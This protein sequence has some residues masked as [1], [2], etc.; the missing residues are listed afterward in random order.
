[1]VA[2]EE[3]ASGDAVSV[4]TGCLTLPEMVVDANIYATL[5]ARGT[6]GVLIDITIICVKTIAQVALLIKETSTS[7]RVRVLMNTVTTFGSARVYTPQVVAWVVHAFPLRFDNASRR[8][9]V[10][11]YLVSIIAILASVF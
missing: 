1:L 4:S 3:V 5:L 11:V 9:A 10:P 2:A 8:A 6:A 7:C